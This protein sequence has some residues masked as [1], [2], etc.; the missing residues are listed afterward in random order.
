MNADSVLALLFEKA[1]RQKKKIIKF[2][3]KYPDA[4]KQL[5]DFVTLYSKY[6]E[7]VGLTWIEIID[8]YL[9]MVNHMLFCRISF[10]K[11][12]KYPTDDQA[13]AIENVYNNEVQMKKYMLGLALSQFLW[14]QHFLTFEFFRQ[15]I[16]KTPGCKNIL[17]VGCGHGLFHLQM[18]DAFSQFT[19]YDIVDIS[20]ISIDITDQ[21]INTFH[22]QLKDK[23]N[24]H[25]CDI[26]DFKT[27]VTY[28]FI[29]IGEVLEHVADP[30]KIL[31]SLKK[32]LTDDGVIFISTCANSPA[33]DHIYHYENICQIQ[34]MIKESGFDLIEEGVYPSEDLSAEELEKRKVDIS[35][36]AMAKR[37]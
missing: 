16:K 28:D 19:N 21:I 23:I 18:I 25:L 29:S 26:N 2:F 34:E 24:L 32:L 35:Y 4:Q 5:N 30:A 10:M 13:N 20:K 37:I 27:D 7:N 6:I 33:I 11:T 14:V 12:G 3:E 31:R 15:E 22:P 36:V 1:P 8:S 9:D 17:E